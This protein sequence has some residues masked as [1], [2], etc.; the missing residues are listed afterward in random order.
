M[1]PVKFIPEHLFF[2]MAPVLITIILFTGCST[3]FNAV[4]KEQA[5][6]FNKNIAD[7]T[8]RILPSDRPYDIQSGINIPVNMT[9]EARLQN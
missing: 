5:A 2:K 9:S 4:R 1:I 8:A 7:K 6:E 3:N